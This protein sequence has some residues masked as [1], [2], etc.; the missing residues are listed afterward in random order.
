MDLAAVELNVLKAVLDDPG[1]MTNFN[2]SDE[3]S[4]RSGPGY[5]QGPIKLIL[6]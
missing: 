6:P 5:N 4:I 2:Q 1:H 3:L